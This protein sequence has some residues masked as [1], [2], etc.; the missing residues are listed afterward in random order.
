MTVVTTTADSDMEE[1]NSSFS[2]MLSSRSSSSQFSLDSPSSFQGTLSLMTELLQLYDG[3]DSCDD[4]L[5]VRECVSQ[6]DCLREH[7]NVL[8][9]SSS[10]LKDRIQKKINDCASSYDFEQ[11]KLKSH[12]QQLRSLEA[13]VTNIRRHNL[14]LRQ[15]KQ[16]AEEKIKKYVLESNQEIEK[17]DEVEEQR[18]K[19]LP[20]LKQQISL[21][22]TATGI[23]WDYDYVDALVGEVSIPSQNVL[24]KFMIHVDDESEFQIANKLWGM[25]DSGSSVV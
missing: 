10:L 23:K 5:L 13:N 11:Q 18:K 14:D 24:K 7:A 16:I 12:E 1:L 19:E 17:I 20:R 25:M 22:A 8:K 6:N 9:K 2:K 3:P 15:K 4:A 21:L